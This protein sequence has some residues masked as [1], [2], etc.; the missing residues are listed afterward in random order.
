[1]G[2]SFLPTRIHSV[3]VE[4]GWLVSVMFADAW[5]RSP[6]LDG[7]A[8]CI[9]DTCQALSTSYLFSFSVLFI[10]F[11]PSPEKKRRHRNERKGKKRKKKRSFDRL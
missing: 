1:M 10:L 2:R 4:S 8:L 6:F 11:P 9:Y 7:W 5:Q 3:S